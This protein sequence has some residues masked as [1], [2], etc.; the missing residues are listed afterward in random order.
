MKL[1]VAPRLDWTRHSAHH[2]RGQ[3]LT[4]ALDYRE[5]SAET[6]GAIRAGGRSDAWLRI[7]CCILSSD[8]EP[9]F[10]PRRGSGEGR[11]E[12]KEMG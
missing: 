10:S 8:G 6:W 1:H 3:S 9:I 4:F 5:V 12:G 2:D 7:T 11:P